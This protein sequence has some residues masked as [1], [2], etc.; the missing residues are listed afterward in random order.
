MKMFLALFVLILS[1]NSF[2]QKEIR[3]LC[4][5][6]LDTT[7]DKNS[8]VVKFNSWKNQAEFQTG[9]SK[10]KNAT[11]AYMGGD[12]RSI[13]LRFNGEEI[14][15]RVNPDAVLDILLTSP[16]EI[17]SRSAKITARIRH[18]LTKVFSWSVGA[19]YMTC[20]HY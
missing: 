19:E 8:I 5:H 11:E 6:S 3:L 10:F 20:H 18:R 9:N 16:I 17:T 4:N 7:Y 2:A 1:M 15:G 12:L 13:Q 14:Y